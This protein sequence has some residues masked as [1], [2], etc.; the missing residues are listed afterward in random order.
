MD[1]ELSRLTRAEEDVL[2]ALARG[3]YDPR[4]AVSRLAALTP[5]RCAAL[6]AREAQLRRANAF[7]RRTK[8]L[9]RLA[10]RAEADWRRERAVAGLRRLG[11]ASKASPT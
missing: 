4:L 8:L 11:G 6:E 7:G 10:E 3:A 2:K 9:E 1:A 5:A